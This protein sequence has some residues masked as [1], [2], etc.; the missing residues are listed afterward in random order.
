MRTSGD[1]VRPARLTRAANSSRRAGPEIVS[2]SAAVPRTT[3]GPS[4][5]HHRGGRLL[6]IFDFRALVVAR[7]RPYPEHIMV[8]Y[9]Q[10]DRRHRP[11]K[12][13]V[14]GCVAVLVAAIAVFLWTRS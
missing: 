14:A 1:T 10:P 9:A 7:L 12:V 11:V 3:S 6:P 5:P 13:I 8:T 2:G 4:T